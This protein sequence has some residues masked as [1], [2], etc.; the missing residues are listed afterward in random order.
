MSTTT[1]N[2]GLT[3]PA[4]T[5]YY[6]IAVP[7]ANMDLIDAQMKANADTA[8]DKYGKAETLS[9]ATKTIYGL[10]SGAVPDD[11]LTELAPVIGLSQRN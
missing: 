2:Y 5:D 7:N 10:D 8:A 1:A 3:K 9:A 6:D 11:V 4:V